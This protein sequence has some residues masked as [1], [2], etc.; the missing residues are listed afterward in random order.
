[1]TLARSKVTLADIAD[2]NVTI[3][4]EDDVV[5]EVIQRLWR[6]PSLMALVVRGHGVPRGPDVVGVITKEHVADTVASSVKIYAT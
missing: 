2:R 3:V 1:M 6:K 4:R 5:F